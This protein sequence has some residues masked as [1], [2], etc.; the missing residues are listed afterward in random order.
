MMNNGFFKLLTFVLSTIVAFIGVVGVRQLLPSDAQNKTQQ[1]KPSKTTL[2]Q[3][4]QELE[5]NQVCEQASKAVVTVKDGKGHGSGFLVSQDGLIITNAHV[6]EGSP[7]VVT[8]VFQDGQQAPADVIGFAHGGV[9]LA[10]LR[11]Q[12]RKN[13][14]HLN[15]AR[16]G[17][18]KVGYRVFAIGS[19]LDP[20]NRDTCTQGHISR[21]REEGI[22][23]HTA[24]TNQGNSGGPLLNSQG[25][26]IG[27]NTWGA[28]AP[29][30]DKEGNVIARTPSGTGINL[31]L[32]VSNVQS[33]IADIQNRR[34]ASQS[35]LERRQEPTI[36]NITLNG[37]VIDGS[38]TTGDRTLKDGRFVNLYQFQGRAN[39][40]IVIDMKSQKINSY[41]TLYQVNGS[42]E[43][44]EVIKIAENDD[45]GP[46]D[47]NAQIATTLPADGFY[48]IVASSNER[49]EMGNYSLRAASYP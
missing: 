14:P 18:A 21:I 9:D 15:L 35:T 19:P 7:S 6:V 38:L 42:S 37:Q 33:F 25:D 3:T 24:S 10:A 44:S 40:Q 16:P 48:F 43:D 1:E 26:V 49:G 13:L 12:N 2:A 45:R 30:Y 39:Q 27:V 47:L 8:V 34:V 29:V 22:V 11:I 4:S 17:S 28:T 31:A 36:A 32:P 41:L 5:A 23:Q 20:E 46:N